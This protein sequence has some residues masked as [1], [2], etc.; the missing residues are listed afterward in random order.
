MRRKKITISLLTLVILFSLA[1]AAFAQEDAIG[2]LLIDTGYNNTTGLEETMAIVKYGTDAEPNAS[3]TVIETNQDEWTPIWSKVPITW[4]R[5][6]SANLLQQGVITL[7]KEEFGLTDK[8]LL[9][10]SN[11]I[12]TISIFITRFAIEIMLIGFNSQVVVNYGQEIVQ[13]ATEIWNG[14]QYSG[15]RNTLLLLVLTLSGFYHIFR[16]LQARF[17]DIIRAAL[18]TILVL[19]LSAV[20]FANADRILT[21]ATDIIDSISGAV[22]SVIATDE[23]IPIEDPQQRGQVAF[24]SNVWDIMV[25]SPWAYAQFGTLDTTGLKVSGEEYE[26]LHNEL[27]TR[28]KANITMNTRL[29]Q[30]LLSLPPGSPDRQRAVDIFQDEEISHGGHPQTTYTLNPT[31][32][33]EKFL[34]AL[35]TL[36]GSAVFALFAC[37]MGALLFIA[38]ITIIFSLAIAPFIAVV[39]LIPERGWNIALR[40]FKTLLSALFAKIYYGVYIGIIFLVI[41]VLLTGS[42]MAFLFKLILLCIILIFGF[43][44]RRKFVDTFSEAINLNNEQKTPGGKFLTTFLKYRIVNQLIPKKFKFNMRPEHKN[45]QYS[46]DKEDQQ[47]SSFLY[48]NEQRKKQGEE[49]KSTPWYWSRATPPDKQ[50]PGGTTNSQAPSSTYN[51]QAPTSTVTNNKK[52]TNTTGTG[53]QATKGQYRHSPMPYTANDKH[54]D[55][56]KSAHQTQPIKPNHATR[57]TNPTVENTQ[58]IQQGQVQQPRTLKQNTVINN[59]TQPSQQ[60]TI[61]SPQPAPGQNK[62]VNEKGKLQQPNKKAHAQQQP[63]KQPVKLRRLTIVKP[64]NP[65]K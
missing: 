50:T 36:L 59:A 21:A 44:Y 51:N 4:Y 22:F 47:Q 48:W 28:A 15:I 17:S 61:S 10:V 64:R 26:K 20:Y 19:G 52:Q 8:I 63:A 1:V 24:A 58:Q 13:A 49:K 34:Y 23:E 30:I 12:F 6:D 41:G 3:Q 29:D 40:W 16:L 54:G 11:I 65:R 53:N 37:F 5:F 32:S 9:F 27:E 25:I 7:L 31:V 57:Q 2:R 62:D 14:G 55:S 39:A 46:T 38:D 18:V 60:S 33:F 56:N 43:I 45:K 42:T 35:I